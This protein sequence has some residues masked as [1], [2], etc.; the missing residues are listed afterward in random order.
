MPPDYSQRQPATTLPRCTVSRVLVDQPDHVRALFH[1]AKAYREL[2]EFDAALEKL[3]RALGR[4]GGRKDLYLTLGEVY[5][6]KSEPD[7]ARKYRELFRGDDWVVESGD[8]RDREEDDRVDADRF[9]IDVAQIEESQ[10]RVSAGEEEADIPWALGI[11]VCCALIALGAVATWVRLR[12][13][14]AAADEVVPVG[15]APGKS[16]FGRFMK[17]ETELAAQ[18][19]ATS[20]ETAELDQQIEDKWR[21]LRASAELFPSAAS[22]AADSGLEDGHLDHILDQVETIRTALD[23]QDERARVYADIVRLQN[24]KIEAMGDQIRILRRHPK[25]S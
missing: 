22:A 24:M 5:R 3:Y 7:S 10:D 4:S 6:L 21:E 20:E 12:G 19:K 15:N 9:A 14:P 11:A 17:A 16:R 18:G 13:R 25:K 8:R 1:A 23:L 2:G